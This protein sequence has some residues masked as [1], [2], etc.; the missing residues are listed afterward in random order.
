M[1]ATETR[2]VIRDSH[3][4]VTNDGSDAINFPSRNS[5]VLYRCLGSSAQYHTT[6]PSRAPGIHIAPLHGAVQ[7]TK[8]QYLV[9]ARGADTIVRRGEPG[10]S[11]G[12]LVEQPSKRPLALQHTHKMWRV[13]S[14]YRDG[15]APFPHALFTMDLR[16]WC[17]TIKFPMAVQDATRGTDVVT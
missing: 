6:K 17:M 11:Y 10:H 12:H 7:F 4:A 2:D 16:A 5:S 1:I 14:P 8:A 13:N 15:T 3:V 9:G